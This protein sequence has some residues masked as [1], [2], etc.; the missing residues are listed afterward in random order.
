MWCKIF[1]N[2]SDPT[3]IYEFGE[4]ELKSV[5]YQIF[6]DGRRMI[7]ITKPISPTNML[8]TCALALSKKKMQVHVYHKEELIRSVIA[9]FDS[10]MIFEIENRPYERFMLLV[11][12]VL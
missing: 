4:E 12:E 3:T 10:F 2:V 1:E 11:E 5:Y 9:K 6:E 8:E 7:E